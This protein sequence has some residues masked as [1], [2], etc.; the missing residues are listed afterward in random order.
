M[1]IWQ[2]VCRTGFRVR[3]LK[4]NCGA[5]QSSAVPVLMTMSEATLKIRWND[6]AE[7]TNLPISPDHRTSF[8]R[9]GVKPRERYCPS[10][11]SIVYSRR[12]RRCGV[13]GQLLPEECLFTAVEAQ[14]VEL[15]LRIER[16]RHR[17][18]LKKAM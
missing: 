14:N 16:Q 7:G 11:D 13:C 10:C 6:C 18:W 3:C 15:L 2:R 5:E 9:L 4:L 1:A 12:H 8:F 17:A